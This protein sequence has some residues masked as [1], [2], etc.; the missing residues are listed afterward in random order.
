MADGASIRRAYQEML[1]RIESVPGVEAAAVTSLVPLSGRDNELGF[2][3]GDGP[4]PPEDQM[5]S[6][7]SFITAPDYLQ[8][9]NIPLRAGRFFTAHDTLAMPPVVVIDE[10]MAK[11]VFQG[12]NPLGREI[13]IMV[14]GR[15]QI[16]G[17]AGHVKHWGLDGNEA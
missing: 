11:R 10:A 1:H 4:R 2:W 3:L 6:A 8:A 17:V 12:E 13:N 14:I 9:M 16:V 5:H 7:L 15:V